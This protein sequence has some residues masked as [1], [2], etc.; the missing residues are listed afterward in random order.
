MIKKSLKLVIFPHEENQMVLSVV[1]I[2]PY[3]RIFARV[4]CKTNK[5]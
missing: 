3:A 2:H 4:I 5:K 1:S